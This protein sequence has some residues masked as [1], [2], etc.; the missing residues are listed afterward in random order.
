MKT[1][2]FIACLWC[3]SFLSFGQTLP[4]VTGSLESYWWA[5]LGFN[6]TDS[7]SFYMNSG[8][9]NQIAAIGA[10]TPANLTNANNQFTGTNS[11]F[12]GLT[13]GWQQFT[14][15]INGAS[16]N[17]AQTYN[18]LSGSWLSAAYPN[19]VALDYSYL[20]TYAGSNYLERAL[21][22]VPDKTASAPSL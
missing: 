5:T 17:L 19:A 8:T 6:A 16:F 11:F 21:G 13:L 12:S 15:A 3:V 2:S 20:G 10:T 22:F 4:F 18:P 14:G 9:S 1:K 7:V